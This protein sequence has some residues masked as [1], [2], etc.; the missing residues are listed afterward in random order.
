MSESLSIVLGLVTEAAIFTR[1]L[2]TPMVRL[3]SGFDSHLLY[4]DTEKRT[5]A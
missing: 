1:Y 4:S 2:H 5:G 3:I